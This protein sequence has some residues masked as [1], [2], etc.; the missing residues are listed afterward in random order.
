VA[1]CAVKFPLLVTV[2]GAVVKSASDISPAHIRT[3]PLPS[4]V[5][6]PFNGDDSSTALLDVIPATI[7]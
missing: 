6:L 5:T 2:N 1:V 4:V 3:S 7:F